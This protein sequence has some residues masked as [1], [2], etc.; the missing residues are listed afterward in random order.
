LLRSQKVSVFTRTVMHPVYLLPMPVTSCP[1]EIDIPRLPPKS[2][3]QHFRP[4]KTRSTPWTPREDALLIQGVQCYGMSDWARISKMIGSG[5]SRAQC[6]QRWCRCLNPTIVKGSWDPE[7]DEKLLMLIRRYG[8]KNWV[9][10]S[11]GMETRSDVQ[12]RQRYMNMHR[13]SEAVHQDRIRLPSIEDLMATVTP[14]SEL[15]KP[16]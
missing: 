10:I 11:R 8:T 5:R 3:Q 12:C 4:P 6:A 2:T 7:E 13:S 15:T 14:P 16:Q 9:Q 1:V